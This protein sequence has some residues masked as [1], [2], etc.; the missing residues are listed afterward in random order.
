[1]K[2]NLIF[3]IVLTILFAF[4]LYYFMLPPINLQSPAF[5]A[6]AIIILIFYFMISIPS[7]FE[8][9]TFSLMGKRRLDIDKKA[10]YIIYT[11][12]G[13]VL[14]IILINIIL[15]PV[16]NAKSYYNRIS[17]NEGGNFSNDIGEV[18]FNH[19]PLL[20]KDSSQKLGDR[21]MGQMTDLVSQFYVS[22]LYT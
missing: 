14:L 3:R 16:F 10:R 9:I 18:D 19:I 2:K 4:I 6:F 17:I 20:D 1:M 11:I 12:L 7:I 22:E 21:V 13:I 5:Y 15:S 8:N